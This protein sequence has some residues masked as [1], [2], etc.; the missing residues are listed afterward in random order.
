MVHLLNGILCSRNKEGPPILHD[1]IDG[2]GEHYAKWNKPG[3]ERLIPYDL[4]FKWNLINKTN[5][6]TKQ[7]Q[8]LGN[9]ERTDSNQSGGEGDNRG[10]KG[11]GRQGTCINDP[12][13]KTMGQRKTECGRWQWV[14]QG[15]V[16]GWNGDNY[17]WTTIKKKGKEQTL[18]FATAGNSW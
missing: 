10:K 6:W 15:R 9:K 17:N 1:T 14:G 11:K 7:N 18:V 2:T 8:R 12:W 4:T 5:K 3:G 13:T 16:M